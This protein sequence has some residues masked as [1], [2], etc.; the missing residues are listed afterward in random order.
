MT[1]GTTIYTA[2]V[3]C[4]VAT[5]LFHVPLLL[6]Q[7]QLF[8]LKTIV[9]KAG[10]KP[11]DTIN[12]TYRTNIRWANDIQ[13]VINDEDIELACLEAGKHVLVD[14]P[15]TPTYAE[16]AEL[17]RIAQRCNRQLLTFQNRRLDGD[18]LTV[19][20]LIEERAI[21]EVYEVE[22]QGEQGTYTKR[23]HDVQEGQ[24]KKHMS[25]WEPEFGVEP[26][27]QWGEI[28]VQNGD[29][30]FEFDFLPTL[31]GEYNRIYPNIAGVL[32]GKEEP[33]VRWEESAA[34]VQILQLAFQTPTAAYT[35][36][37]RWGQAST[38]LGNTLYVHGGKTD[39]YNAY[40]YS[41]APGT[42]DLLSLDLSSSFAISDPPWTYVS[43]SSVSSTSQ[44]PSVAFHSLTAF[45]ERTMLLFGGDGGS[46]MSLPS[47]SNSAW[48]LNISGSS[49]P[50][51]VEQPEGWASEPVRSIRHS[52]A[53]SFGRVWIIGGEKADG[54]NLPVVGNFVFQP[55]VPSF[56]LLPTD[57]APPILIGHAAVRLGANLMLVFGGYDLSSNTMV[58][59]SILWFVDTSLPIPVWTTSTAVGDVP[60]PRREFAFYS[61]AA[62]L[63][64]SQSPM[65]WSTINGFEQI[66]ARRNHMAVGIG[67]QVLI[68]FGYGTNGP[69][70]SSLQMFESGDSSW[71]D[72]FIPVPSPTALPS[73]SSPAVTIPANPPTQSGPQI[74][75][76]SDGVTVPVS[77]SISQTAT[78]QVTPVTSGASSHN[79]TP[80]PIPTKSQS[81]PPHSTRSHSSGTLLPTASTIPT[82][83]ADG[84]SS[85]LTKIAIGAVVAVIALVGL[86][87]CGA[88]IALRKRRPI[89]RRGDG[90]ARLISGELGPGGTHERYGTDEPKDI[91]VAGSSWQA[92]HTPRRQ[93][94][95]LGLSARPQARARFD[96]LHDEDIREF[97]D[98]SGSRTDVRRNG[99]MG[100]G[101]STWGDIVNASASSLRVVGAALGIGQS[102]RQSSYSSTPPTAHDTS[103]RE[104]NVSDP[105]LNP[106]ERSLKMG[107][108][109]G[110]SISRPRTFRQESSSSLRE[111][112]YTN[113]FEDS[114]N[115]PLLS[116]RE[117]DGDGLRSPASREELVG[118]FRQQDLEDHGDY[119]DSIIPASFGTYGLAALGRPRSSSE[120]G[121]SSGSVSSHNATILGSGTATV[122]GSAS[123]HDHHSTSL[124]NS[125]PSAPIRRSDSWWSRFSKGSMRG[126]RNVQHESFNVVRRLSRSSDRPP[127]P[128][129]RIDFRDPAPPPVRTMAI[130]RESGVSPDPSPAEVPLARPPSVIIGSVGAHRRSSSSLVT[131]QTADSAVLEQMGQLD[132][133]QRVRT[134][135]TYHTQSASQ[136]TNSDSIEETSSARP[137]RR[138]RLS[139]VPASP[140]K[141]IAESH[142]ESNTPTPSLSEDHG[143]IVASPTEATSSAGHSSPIKLAAPLQVRPRQR[144][145]TVADRVADYERR[146]SQANSP[147][148]PRKSPVSGELN[149]ERPRSRVRVEYGFVQRPELFI[150]NPDGRTSPST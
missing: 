36:E 51:W 82:E 85:N 71:G 34:V 139:I 12:K 87:L 89:W 43:G 17:A 94:T 20:K 7:K 40:T 134:A 60:T 143:T 62:I 149:N 76:R 75:T 68:A 73:A 147:T 100:S 122:V 59:M 98:M 102:P 127:K 11:I 123:S 83:S 67:S 136:D 114:A 13:S 119:D 93:W 61:D 128:D 52:A 113:P 50:T 80:G 97:G 48:L 126:D 70:S 65:R 90:T 46:S 30:L 22:S 29:G 58:N 26:K 78:T 6:A 121:H 77:Q 86:I 142:K 111:I 2:V 130:I 53:G 47:T 19:K 35:P 45:D 66:G 140:S 115:D 25:P 145:G 18:F 106:S 132:I 8:T 144:T 44:G 28:E 15:V 146:M 37:A 21:G 81:F 108:S 23:G 55:T 33:L 101:R 133:I 64:V 9:E 10:P 107:P 3:G 38:I 72:T 74:S 5:Q 141:T 57:N 109:T 88:Y 69:A 129:P 105:F 120:L 148:S 95:L 104:K 135:S 31:K 84:P 118:A 110:L 1:V 27:S 112:V 63:D 24:M 137:S 138:P 124:L 131:V 49:T 39:P 103:S 14:K 92:L 41:S 91:P 99:S 56:D 42:N 125:T 16:A 117:G 96:I 116:Q 32:E 4:G 54:S 150:A 79:S